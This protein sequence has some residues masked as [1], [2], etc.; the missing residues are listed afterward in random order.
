[1]G[2]MAKRFGVNALF[3]YITEIDKGSTY[4]NK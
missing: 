2:M 1:M 3:T 4:K